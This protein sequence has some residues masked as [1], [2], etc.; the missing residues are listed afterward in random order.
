VIQ[1]YLYY[2]ST[3]KHETDAVKLD[4]YAY[5]DANAAISAFKQYESV[6]EKYLYSSDSYIYPTDGLKSL[7]SFTVDRQVSDSWQG[8]ENCYVDLPLTEP[9]IYLINASFGGK[10]GSKAYS[11][12]K[13]FIIQITDI[14]TRQGDV[15]VG[16]IHIR[17]LF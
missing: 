14:V 4:I 3:K 17:T 12:T 8:Y 10:I 2:D 1:Y 15:D 5:A 7:G 13:Q 9:G 16:D 6:K 11:E